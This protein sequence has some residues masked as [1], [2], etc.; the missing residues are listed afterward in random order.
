M[1]KVLYR[2]QYKNVNPILMELTEEYILWDSVTIPLNRRSEQL[3]LGHGGDMLSMIDVLGGEVERPYYGGHFISV[4][5]NTF[6]D[7]LE[8]FGKSPDWTTYQ[9]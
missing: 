6:E 2:F 5:P 3:V 9:K 7:V 8:K 1:M 4:P